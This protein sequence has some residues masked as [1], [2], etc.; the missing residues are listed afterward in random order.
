MGRE[1]IP[2]CTPCEWLKIYEKYFA[3]MYYSS[4]AINKIQAFNKN[5]VN[6]LM[7]YTILPRYMNPR[8]TGQRAALTL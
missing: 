4:Q 5:I 1:W 6:I 3:Y 8:R 2:A 7:H